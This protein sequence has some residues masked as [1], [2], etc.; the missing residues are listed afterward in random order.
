MF[1]Y[2]IWAIETMHSMQ[3]LAVG[4]LCVIIPR[5]KDAD[6]MHCFCISCRDA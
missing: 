4:Q 5:D 1:K 2:L 3:I 6:M